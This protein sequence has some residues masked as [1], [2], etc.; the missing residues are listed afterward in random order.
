[1]SETDPQYQSTP[2]PPGAPIV[3]EPKPEIVL[4]P[5]TPRPDFWLVTEPLAITRRGVLQEWIWQSCGVFTKEQLARDCA[6]EYPCSVITYVP[7]ENSVSKETITPP[8]T[9]RAAHFFP[10]TSEPLPDLLTSQECARVLR[11]EGKHVAPWLR[12][13]IHRR[14]LPYIRV[15]HSNLI[16]REALLK[17]IE[18]Q[19]H[20]SPKPQ[21]RRGPRRK[22]GA[23]PA[24]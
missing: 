12:K 20:V 11:F 22:F 13:L 23:P 8:V 21:N 5:V 15:R 17:W 4:P 6:A 14:E 19:Q 16:P 18:E 10:G 9:L 24:Q 3:P 2:R 1:M 7:G